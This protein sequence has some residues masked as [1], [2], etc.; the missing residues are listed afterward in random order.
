MVPG[1]IPLVGY[2]NSQG[3]TTSMSCEGHPEKTPYMSMFW[4]QFDK[5]ITKEDIEKWMKCH[6][7]KKG[8]FVS[9]G[10]FVYRFYVGASGTDIRLRYEASNKE[11]A[12]EDL[13]RWEKEDKCYYS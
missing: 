2:F 1:V 13:K 12:M 7:D 9:C 11:V 4:I 10:H 5:T 6:L 3:L 8:N